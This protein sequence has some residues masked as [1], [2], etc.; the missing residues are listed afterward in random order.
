[1]IFTETPLVGAFLID[2]E[3]KEDHRGFFARSWCSEEFE[4]HGL[5]P[6][7]AQINLGYSGKRGTLRGMHYQSRWCAARLG[8]S[9]T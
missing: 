8:R 2:L 5:N 6:V 3:R 9:S 7:L 1:M 4:R